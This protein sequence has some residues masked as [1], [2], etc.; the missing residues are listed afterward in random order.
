MFCL[1]FKTHGSL[2]MFRFL[3]TCHFVARYTCIK[4]IMLLHPGLPQHLQPAVSSKSGAKTAPMSFMRS[5]WSI[6]PTRVFKRDFLFPFL[7]IKVRCAGGNG[8]KDENKSVFVIEGIFPSSPLAEQGAAEGASRRVA[9]DA[10]C[11][12]FDIRIQGDTLTMISAASCEIL[13]EGDENA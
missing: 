5:S 10:R 7:G 13:F 9:C 11:K 6:T 1:C 8:G 2:T 3:I 12:A 4:S